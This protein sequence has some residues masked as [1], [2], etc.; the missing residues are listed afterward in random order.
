MHLYR[1]HPY[2]TL[3]PTDFV[4]EAAG[5]NLVGTIAVFIQNRLRLI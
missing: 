2:T 4:V 3:T 5:S 1:A